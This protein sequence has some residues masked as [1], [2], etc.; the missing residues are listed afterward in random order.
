MDTVNIMLRWT[1]VAA[2]IIAV[3]GSFFLRFI[4]L[5]V[6]SGLP[7]EAQASTRTA[8]IARWKMVLRLCIVLILGSGLYNYMIVTYPAH[9][10]QATYHMLLGIKI[11]LALAV[12]T[13][14]EGLVGKAPPFAMMRA[15]P[16]RWLA[17]NLL[18]AAA[19]VAISSYV[20]FL[21]V[22][23]HP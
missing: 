9:R 3:G 5:P 12:F 7:D 14:A 15:N 19:I 2:V 18:L 4:L 8:V 1:H 22:V 17:I 6:L 23:S 10:G 20:K 21:P 13:I 11:M 16:R